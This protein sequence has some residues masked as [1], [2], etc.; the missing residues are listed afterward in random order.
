MPIL[1]PA[2][3]ETLVL[4]YTPFI[5]STARKLIH[6]VCGPL[7]VG[8][9]YD[10]LD[11]VIGILQLQYVIAAQR[12][13]PARNRKLSTYAQ[14][15][16]EHEARRFLESFMRRGVH[17]PNY[18]LHRQE[19]RP[20]RA[21]VRSLIGARERRWNGGARE[22]DPPVPAEEETADVPPGFWDDVRREL[23]EIEWLILKT[24]FLDKRP[25]AGLTDT[26]GKSRA[27]YNL[28]MQ[29]ILQ[30]LRKRLPHYAELL[31]F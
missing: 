20:P 6:Q 31:V 29:Q 19:T 3:I 5:R 9:Y 25:L 26:H 4:Q 14:H 12:F 8:R 27:W 11:D 24:R 28:K 7:H 16:A 10:V 21:S 2:E 22:D 13:D 30:L 18:L 15:V 17:V 23:T 1:T